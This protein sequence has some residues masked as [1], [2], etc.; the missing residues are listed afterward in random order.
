MLENINTNIQRALAAGAQWLLDVLVLNCCQSLSINAACW[1]TVI[2]T[3]QQAAG[4][5]QVDVGTETLIVFLEEDYSDLVNPQL[6][7]LSKWHSP[8]QKYKI[9]TFHN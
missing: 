7:G 1:P 4:R 2:S 3:E 6:T 5:G 8:G 9:I